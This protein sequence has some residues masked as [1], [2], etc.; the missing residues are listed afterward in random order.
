MKNFKTK[1][2]SITAAI[3]LTIFFALPQT[4]KAQANYKV[5]PGK[6]VTIKVLGSSNIHDWTMT[7]TGIESQGQFKFEGGRLHALTSFSLVA[8]AKSLKSES[9]SMD[10]RCYKTIKADQY[11]KITFKLGSAIVTEV[12]KNQYTIKA[13]GDLTISGSTQPVV[14]TVTAVVNADNTITCTG[15]QKIKLTDYKIDPPT[16]LLGAMKVH[17]DLT[18]QYNLVYK[19]SQ[20]FTSN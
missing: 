16:F 12:Q 15:A 5:S 20:L 9:T 4:L 2:L 3:A 14:L 11:P 6:D 10:G 18:I 8:E 7:A 17:N 19:N 13:S 1:V